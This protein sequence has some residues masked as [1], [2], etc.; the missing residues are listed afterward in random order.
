MAEALFGRFNPG[1]KLPV[2]I[3]R[4]VGQ[5]PIYYRHKPSAGRSYPY[6][7]YVD[8]SAQ[9][10]WPFGHG[11][12]YTQFE[13]SDLALA[14]TE[15]SPDGEIE[16]AVTV[17]NTGDREGD[18]VVQL[19]FHDLIGSVTRPVKELK[20]FLRLSLLAGQAARVTFTV[21]AALRLFTTVP[22][23][24]L[25][26]RASSRSLV[27][28]SSADIRLQA[29]FVHYRR[30]DPGQPQSLFQPRDGPTH[31]GDDRRN[32]MSTQALQA[33]A[34]FNVRDYAATGQREDNAQAALQAAIDACAAAGGGMVYLPPGEYTTGTLHLRRH[35]RFHVEAGATVWSSKDPAAFDQRPCS[36]PKMSH[37]ITLE[38]RGTIDGQAEYYW[39]EKTFHDWYIYP[40]QLVAEQYGLPLL[41]SFPTEN[42]IGNLVTSSAATTCASRT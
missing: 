30:R 32:R 12:S 20:G 19:Y 17:T 42:S 25:S 8:E 41:R 29:Q 3:A 6:N 35:V 9:P 2:T 39:A 34:V 24:T 1:G 28:S 31:F 15:I 38:G 27:G 16:V 4:S 5:V 21:P 36:M 37:H 10:L 40:N 23:A 7:D 11:L 13:Y 14:S 26:S 22:C 18:E 33:M